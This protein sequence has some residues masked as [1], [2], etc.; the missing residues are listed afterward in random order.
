MLQ[1]RLIPTLLMKNGSLVK[2]RRFD[3]S[4]TDLIGDPCNSLRIFNELA[5]DEIFALDIGASSQGYEPDYELISEIAC[6]CFMPVA[7]GGG[8]RSVDQAERI[9]SCGIEK[10]VINAAGLQHPRLFTEIAEK[11]GSQAVVAS[12]DYTNKK[13]SLEVVSHLGERV[14]RDH[15]S[16]DTWIEYLE[17]HGVGELL[18]TCVDREGTWLGA[19]EDM[20]TRVALNRRVPVIY[21]GGT[22]SVSEARYLMSRFKLGGVALGSAVV[23]SAPNGGVLVHMPEE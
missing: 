19:D 17:M 20:L 11:L 22:R 21:Q 5:V 3:K 2:T 7:Y 15:R 18:L 13:G 4:R 14:P 6:E 9:V 10:V 12:I 1:S 23:Y 16:L 8:I